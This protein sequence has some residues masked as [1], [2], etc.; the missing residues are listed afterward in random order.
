MMRSKG[1]PVG[2]LCSHD[3]LRNVL[4]VDQCRR[5]FSRRLADVALL[6]AAPGGL[7][8]RASGTFA[9]DLSLETVADDMVRRP[10]QG[11]EQLGGARRVRHEPTALDMRR[12]LTD[13]PPGCVPSAVCA[14]T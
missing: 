12:I 9:Q 3:V 8:L 7:E 14:L 2:A 10:P 5:P 13:Q 1:S 4:S 11:G 6:R